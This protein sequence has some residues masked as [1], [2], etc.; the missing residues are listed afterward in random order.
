MVTAQ[1]ALHEAFLLH[2]FAYSETSLIVELFTPDLG[3]IAAVAKGAKR[4]GSALRSVLMPFQPIE[5]SFAGKTELRTL[6]GAEWL[7]G[8][9]M[10]VG[11]AL[12]CGFYMNEL[13]IKLLAKEDPHPTLFG[14]YSDCL[15]ALSQ[16]AASGEKLDTTLRSFEWQLLREVGY[17]PD[18]RADSFGN[19]FEMQQDYRW[20]VGSG[21]VPDTAGAPKIDGSSAAGLIKGQTLAALGALLQ[22][23]DNVDAAKT[24]LSEPSVRMQAKRLTRT[25]L[26]HALDGQ[27]LNSRQILIDLHRL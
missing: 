7:G 16:D 12:I 13:L 21:F 1:R 2:T 11:D 14:A 20:L 6:T 18:L 9:A 24:L 26:N 19:A 22:S 4:K 5:I 15:A 10:P 23:G 3:R 25:V 17:A 8:M 27:K